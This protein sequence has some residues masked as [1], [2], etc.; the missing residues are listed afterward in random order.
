MPLTATHLFRKSTAI[1]PFHSAWPHGMN[2]FWKRSSYAS[3]SMSLTLFFT[4]VPSFPLNMIVTA[5]LLICIRMTGFLSVLIFSKEKP[6]SRSQSL[7]QNH[8]NKS[9]LRSYSHR[10]DPLYL[11]SISCR[12]CHA[13]PQALNEQ[14]VAVM[15]VFQLGAGRS[16]CCTATPI[17]LVLPNMSLYYSFHF[18]GALGWLTSEFFK[19]FFKFLNPHAIEWRTLRG[20]TPSVFAISV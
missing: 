16:M 18:E 10:P 8:M 20:L 7:Y 4:S 1:L 3:V 9:G 6:P 12:I 11:I 15:T 5:K 19:N 13:P 14:G 2:S 17:R